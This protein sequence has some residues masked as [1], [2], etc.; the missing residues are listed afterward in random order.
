MPIV[1]DY[2]PQEQEMADAIGVAGEEWTG[3]AMSGAALGL[4]SAFLLYRLYMQRRI[5]EEILRNPQYATSAEAMAELISRISSM[6]IAK[7]IP[8]LAIN[9]ALGYAQGLKDVGATNPDWVQHAAAT[10]AEKL[11][12]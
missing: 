3:S 12:D 7:W 4:G 8:T 1:Y 9:L 11:G 10:Y 6:Y 5:K 2:T